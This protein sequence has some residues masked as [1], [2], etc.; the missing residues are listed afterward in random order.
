MY[1]TKLSSANRSLRCRLLY[2]MPAK[3]VQLAAIGLTLRWILFIICIFIAKK[4]K[5]IIINISFFAGTT[6][7]EYM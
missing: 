4:T 6:V 2:R 1:H 3:P 7:A 5:K